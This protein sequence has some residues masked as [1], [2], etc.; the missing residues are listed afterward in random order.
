MATIVNGLSI[1][2]KVITECRKRYIKE[3]AANP[4]N[5]P[6]MK[7]MLRYGMQKLY[8]DVTNTNWQRDNKVQ[9][10]ADTDAIL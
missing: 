3:S 7:V 6:F 2:T 8:E 4:T 1:P 9:I 5:E 10:R